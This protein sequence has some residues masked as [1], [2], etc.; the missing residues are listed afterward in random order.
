MRGA[1]GGV[2]AGASGRSTVSGP[3]GGAGSAYRGGEREAMVLVWGGMESG[4]DPITLC[5]PPEMGSSAEAAK[6]SSTCRSRMPPVWC[7][8]T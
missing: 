7:T 2:R 5:R 8:A 4:K 3:L 6:L 1:L